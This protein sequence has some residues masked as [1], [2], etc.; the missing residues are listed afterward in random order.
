M[1]GVH[2]A[3]EHFRQI[4]FEAGFAARILAVE[5]CRTG[6]LGR[7]RRAGSRIRVVLEG[8]VAGSA[9]SSRRWAVGEV[10]CVSARSFEEGRVVSSSA[11]VGSSGRVGRAV[12]GLHGDH[13][14]EAERG[15]TLGPKRSGGRRQT[16]IL[17]REEPAGRGKKLA[18][19]VA[20]PLGARPPRR[21]RPDRRLKKAARGALP[22]S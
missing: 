2:D 21:L 1:E 7:L 16:T 8:A 14:P 17:L 12:R 15:R 19:A 18:D 20:A 13:K 11:M 9:S 4:V 10:A 5:R 6:A 3:P 22:I